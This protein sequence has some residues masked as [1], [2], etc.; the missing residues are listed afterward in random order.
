MAENA[1]VGA[2]TLETRVLIGWTVNACRQGLA[3]SC[4]GEPGVGIIEWLH[5]E[6]HAECHKNIFGPML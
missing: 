5:G 3:L 1:S 2:A 4:G 6:W